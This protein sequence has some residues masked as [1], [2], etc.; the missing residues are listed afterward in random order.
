MKIYN[1]DQIQSNI[2]FSRDIDELI[3]SQKAAFIDFSSGIFDVPLPM[4]FIF[5]DQGSDCHI[6]GA[7]RQDRKNFVIKI[8]GSSKFGNNGTILI[9]DVQTCDLKVILKDDG[10]LTTLRTAIA[11]MI[12]LSIMPR[13]PNKIGIIGS[14]SL[15]KQLFEL[16]KTKYSVD[17]ILFYARNK[18]KASDITNLVCDSAEKIVEKSDIVFT[19][20]S[21]VDPII[22]DILENKNLSIIG[23]GSDDEIKSEISPI[24]FK[25]ADVVI[26]DSKMQAENFGDVS[27]ALKIKAI[28]KNDLV[29]LGEALQSGA[30]IGSKTVIA[31][32]SGI[33]A[34]DLAI[35]EMILSK[36]A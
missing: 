28:D 27:R 31:D 21:S 11:G 25:Q 15:A 33:G 36:M 30:L 6:K 18:V 9:F 29:E 32:L 19:T 17:N 12:C 5:S 14:G 3:N 1:L 16:L 26:V 2:N 20:T 4:Q 13:R 24:L 7:Y 10:F 35:S 34:Q 22:Y 23:L 8:A